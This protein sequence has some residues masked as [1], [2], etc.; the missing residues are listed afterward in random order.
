MIKPK[1]M[2]NV[3]LI[4]ISSSSVPIGVSG[5]VSF[6]LVEV[7]LLRLDDGRFVDVGGS[8]GFGGVVL[9]PLVGFPVDSK[10]GGREIS[11]RLPGVVFF[12]ESFPSNQVLLLSPKFPV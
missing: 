2:G 3:N 9:G 11:G 10:H 8:V 7:H 5:V 1:G 12:S 4:V 6:G